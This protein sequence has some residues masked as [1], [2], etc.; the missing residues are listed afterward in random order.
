MAFVDTVGNLAGVGDGLGWSSTGKNSEAS[1][2]GSA[3]IK[4][5]GDNSHRKSMRLSLKKSRPL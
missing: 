2:R 1:S 4:F 5:P 3:D